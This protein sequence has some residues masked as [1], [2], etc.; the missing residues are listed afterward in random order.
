M[1]RAKTWLASAVAVGTVFAWSLPALSQVIINGQHASDNVSG[2]AVALRAPGNMVNA[3]VIRAQ[4]AA[5][6]A[7]G[8]IE[9][10]ETSRPP[11][12]RAVFLADAIK[13]IFDQL[14]S[15]ILL[16]D[17]LLRLRAGT[18]PVVPQEDTTPPAEN[19]TADD[20]DVGDDNVDVGDVS[21]D[22]GRVDDKNPR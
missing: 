11:S 3:G 16:F 13:I 6:F 20:V 8:G 7:R 19:D 10:V 9:I 15:A 12:P 5:A 2:G 14:N 17:N 1:N 22:E 18:P 4:E 21:A